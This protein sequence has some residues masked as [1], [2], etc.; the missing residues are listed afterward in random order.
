MIR[1]S[2]D[3][4]EVEQEVQVMKEELV[5]ETVC[6]EVEK[7]E[8]GMVKE[9]H[10]V[11][12][13]TVCETGE[14]QQAGG[15]DGDNGNGGVHMAMAKRKM[16]NKKKRIDLRAALAVNSETMINSIFD[17]IIEDSLKL[18]HKEKQVSFVIWQS[19]M[20]YVQYLMNFITIVLMRKWNV[21]TWKNK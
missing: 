7:A 8:E 14:H 1:K 16:K 17:D 9:G 6:V 13:E 4:K 3:V 5:E 20:S 21:I 18:K 10:E 12:E 15:G 11:E 2:K 19:N